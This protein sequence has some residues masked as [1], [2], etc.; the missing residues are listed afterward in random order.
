MRMP[1][2]ENE[3]VESIPLVK[4]RFFSI[5]CG[6]A[7]LLAGV[8]VLIGWWRGLGYL[9]GVVPGLPTMKPDTA[10]ALALCGA[11]LW[12][13]HTA[14]ASSPRKQALC[15]WLSRAA[16]GMVTLIGLSHLIE[17]IAGISLGVDD[18]FFQRA[19]SASQLPNP[20]RMS[21]AS[22]LGLLLIGAAL[23]FLHADS[24]NRRA[25]SQFPALA[26]G[27]IGLAGFLAYLYRVPLL[28]GPDFYSSMALHT[29]LLIV[30]LS[31]GVLLARPDCGLVAE[32]AS[33]GLGGLMARRLLPVVILLP[34]FLGLTWL[35]G[36][37]AGFY[38]AEFT[39][40]LSDISAVILL[41]VLVWQS[42][43]RLN[44]LDQQRRQAEERDLW[45]AAIVDCSN[46]AIIGRT[47]DG[48]INSWNKAAERLYGYRADEAL[49]QPIAMVI[50][51]DRQEEVRDLLAA[52]HQGCAVE[53]YETVRIRKDG[54]R[55]EVSL[56][57]SPVAGRDGRIMGAATVVHDITQHKRGQTLLR[58]SQNQLHAVVHSAMDAVI[59]VDS[60][61]QIVLFNASAEK[62][63]GYPAAEIRGQPLSRLIPQQYRAAHADHLRQFGQAG[64]TSRTIGALNTVRGLRAGGEEF[65]IEASIS[66]FESA[67]EKLFTAIVRDVSER[68][69]TEDALRLAQTQLLSALE[70]GSMG[71][72]SWDILND[73]ID[74]GDPVLKIFGRTREEVAD[75]R[76]ETFL[77]FLHP[78]DRPRIQKA[79]E[80]AVG[81]GTD[82]DVEYRNNRPDGALQW[83]AARG[84]VER[85]A[86]G[87]SW[88]MT[89][90]CMDITARKRLE[91][92]LLQAHKMEALGTLAGGVAHDFNNI[93]MAISGNAQLAMTDLPADHP[94]QHTL[95][96][97]EKATGR[98]TN[99]VRQILTF[100]RQ[101]VPARRVT[102][103]QPEVEE[104]VKLLRATLPARIEIRAEY[105]P[106]APSVS[107]DPTQ[108]H[109]ILMNLGANA[110]H[111]AGES[112]GLVEIRLEGV[113]VSGDL[114]QAAAGLSA[115]RYTRLS[116]R[117]NGRGMDKATLARIFEPFF[118][119]KAVGQGT[120]LGLSV[121]HGIMKNHGGAVTAYSE[122]GKGTIFRLYFPA[123]EHSGEPTGGA[124]PAPSE[125]PLGNGER[126]LYVDDEEDLVL[127]IKR[128]LERMGYVVTGYSDPCQALELFRARP[129]DFDA[130][131][132][133][134]SMPR[135]PGAEL[136]HAVQQIRPDVPVIMASGYLR[137][138]DLEAAARLG[139]RELI[140]KP[141]D[142]AE[143]GRALHRIF[144]GALAGQK[145]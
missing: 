102:P 88:R 78:E 84:R 31:L 36:W 7:A 104:G 113:T 70:A 118:T 33:G 58:E 15:R 103:L 19:L 17:H 43:K 22:A 8:L 91:E 82:Y 98:A 3:A 4:L 12:L 13:Y 112:S 105:V 75:R 52:G 69:R 41:C 111:A 140:S 126:I 86:Q 20:G 93:L 6:Q 34:V 21:A 89:G 144:A 143:L 114:A 127:V 25:G 46:D 16:A 100:S 106:G 49:G 90:V 55:V 1:H 121:V 142:L 135:L 122:V 125:V 44:R 109:Q 115:G 66:Q 45:L 79:L 56:A 30:M 96:T 101:Q 9:T 139:I 67:G 123:A 29:S 62:M 10:S 68:Q 57:Q 64:V 83:I 80:T 26:G 27:L 124:L 47:V 18:L 87:R 85:D 94:L 74:W 76:A 95:A 24:R 120:G 73:S 131:I 38:S 5:F 130:V 14:H 107:A 28:G 119:T 136:A 40:A 60:Q 138:E 133:D 59:M 48:T 2:R 65:P 32:F 116:F 141:Y 132:T 51:S 145:T 61:Q 134:V 71:T 11:S 117:D 23:L 63:F 37:R 81:D 42:T 50:P 110:A 53:R 39:S 72:W 128:R 129:L 92:T 137:P 77:T 99:L 54:S 108:V 35:Y 97:I